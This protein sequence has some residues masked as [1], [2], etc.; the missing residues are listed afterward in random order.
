MAVEIPKSHRDLL[1]KKALAHLA[2]LT[3]KGAPQVTPV[4]F[5]YD[6]TFLRVNSAKDRA[7]D[8]HIRRDARVALSIVDPDDA[9]RYL[10][11]GG[12]VVEIT[13]EG[14]DRHIDALAKTYLGVDRYP[15][16][17][18]TETRVIY[19]IEPLRTFRMG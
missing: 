8:R 17:R 9:Y 14:A 2:T 10:E 15:F 5:D 4:W 6:G 1:N 3:A 19:K 11:I 7:K 16:H 18:A 13:E 12:K